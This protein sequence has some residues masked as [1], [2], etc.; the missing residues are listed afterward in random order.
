MGE[1]P[2]G[3][4]LTPRRCPVP[5]N[6]A[7]RYGRRDARHPQRVRVAPTVG[8]CRPGGR[9][10]AGV[11]V[12]WPGR[13][14]R[15]GCGRPPLWWRSLFCSWA[16]RLLRW[17]AT[18]WRWS[19]YRA[20]TPG[21]RC[22]LCVDHPPFSSTP[23]CA[24]RDRLVHNELFESGGGGARRLAHPPPFLQQAQTDARESRL[25]AALPV[26]HHCNRSP[27][28]PPSSD[29][30]LRFLVSS[31]RIAVSVSPHSPPPPIRRVK[32]ATWKSTHFKT[33]T[34]PI[35][36]RPSRSAPVGT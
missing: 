14:S 24:T 22:W 23:M 3:S 4:P 1:R 15:C 19:T 25:F 16:G 17:P 36:P 33:S 12:P 32:R 5:A 26:R 29:R 27:L 18:A 10:P 11:P 21:R 7:R 6:G 9:R 35:P 30:W 28:P 2:L 31:R 8:R 13:G 34:F 20:S